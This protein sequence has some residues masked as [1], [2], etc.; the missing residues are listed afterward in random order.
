M[1]NILFKSIAILGILGIYHSVSG[2]ENQ[3]NCNIRQYAHYVNLA[4]LAITDSAYQNA[5]VYYDSASQF[6]G[7][8]FAKDR[9]NKAVCYALTGQ[10]NECRSG[11]LY[12]F[13][14][15]LD[16][17]MVKDNPAFIEFLASETGKDFPDLKVELTY[18]TMLRSVYDSLHT[19]DQYFR[20]KHPKNYHD[21]DH[22]TITKIDAS[23][24]KMMNELINEYGW[25]TE[26][27]IGIENPGFQ[28]YEIIIIH[29]HNLKYKIYN[30]AE[31]LKKAYEN[32]M[33]DASKAA[34]LIMESTG[35]DNLRAMDAG[36]VMYVFDPEDTYKS[37]DL[38]L[39]R[40]KTGFFRLQDDKKEEINQKRRT[41]GLEP[42]DD[43]R[44]KV[45]FSERDK[46][47]YFNF[48]GGK[49]GFTTASL[50]DYE[51]AVKNIVEF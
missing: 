40:H 30:Y 6:I 24:V 9:Y 11:L 25:P 12:L 16:R 34:Y 43:L 33:I 27:L 22:D 38:K 45:M 41:F 29:Q 46:R 19:A 17:Q 4:E 15:G 14:K 42:I 13:G 8:P 26:D 7:S 10:F 5:I 3:G 44:R 48:Y 21:F 20:R 32:C 36:L 18:N 28:Q 39:Y 51:Y 49:S 50:E 35:Q 1:K 37:E 31:D 2:Q 23:N 47:F